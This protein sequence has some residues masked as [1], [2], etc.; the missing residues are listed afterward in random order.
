MRKVAAIVASPG[1]LAGVYIFIASFFGL[2]KEETP[3]TAQVP[4]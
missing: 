2:R 1:F 4:D 3:W